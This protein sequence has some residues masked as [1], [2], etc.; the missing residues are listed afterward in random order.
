MTVIILCC[1]LRGVTSLV[2]RVAARFKK[3]FLSDEGNTIYQY[4]ERQVALRNSKKAERLEK[5]R[6][7]V[8]KLRAR[9]K[10]D[11]TSKDPEVALTALVVGLMDHTAERVGNEESKEERGH[12]GVTGWQKS[13][14]S[15][16]KGH[17]TVKY[18]GK[19]GVKQKKTVT[20]KALVS[21]LRKA[22]S[23]CKDGD[24]FCHE[25]G[26]VSASRV[27]GY[28]EE[29]GIT[30]KDL[31]GLHANSRMQ[32]NLKAVRRKGG[33]LP[34]D[35]KERK[36]QLKKE[37]KKALALT[38]EDVGHTKETLESDYL[39][40][41]LSDSYLKDGT[42]MDK[43]VKAVVARHLE[44]KQ[45]DREKRGLCADNGVL[46]IEVPWTSEDLVGFVRQFV[47]RAEA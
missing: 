4:S 47:Q 20:E 21:A 29:F 15:F 16:S 1:C 27:N 38:A 36:A 39:V 34:G 41:G 28:L 25:G 45:R 23:A 6:K 31:R 10:K 8:H 3:K 17:A 32:D 18:T 35:A 37:F 44:Q 22:H 9:V 46:L 42:V 12:V 11:L 2:S 14:V 33:E 40:P 5:L 19:S 43:M 30:A 24:I 26:K 7:S 13:H